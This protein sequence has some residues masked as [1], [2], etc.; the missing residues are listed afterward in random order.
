MGYILTYFT[1]C[2]LALLGFLEL[3]RIILLK[4]FTPKRMP[5]C[6]L[7]LS[8]KDNVKDAEFIIRSIA[9]RI[10]WNKDLPY[11]E[12]IVTDNGLDEKT[13]P[14]LRALCEEYKFLKIVPADRLSSYFQNL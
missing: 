13:A 1:V 10:R 14:I 2:L 8:M 9:E 3:A 6:S 4:I 11:S 12:I 7:V 5:P